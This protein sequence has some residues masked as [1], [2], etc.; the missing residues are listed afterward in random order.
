M[1]TTNQV[2]AIHILL[3]KYSIDDSVYRV[4]LE[5]IY[6]VSTSKDL[7]YIQADDLIHRMNYKFNEDYKRGYLKGIDKF[8]ENEDN[9]E[10]FKKL[11]YL[12]E[13]RNLTDLEK[14]MFN[15]LEHEK[16]L[17]IIDNLRDKI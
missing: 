13:N 15:N 3:R 17:G 7:N 6:N 1:I 2:K 12:T 5:D 10:V 8:I 16:Q 14:Q 11:V 9:I 4:W